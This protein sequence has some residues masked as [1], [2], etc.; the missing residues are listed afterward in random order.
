MTKSF[1]LVALCALGTACSPHES[2][3]LAPTDAGLAGLPGSAVGG[4]GGGGATDA[5]RDMGGAGA[6]GSGATGGGRD[7]RGAGAG[8]AGAGGRVTGGA[9]S[10]A[11]SATGTAMPLISRDVPAFAASGDPSAANDDAPATAWGSGALPS[12]IAYDLSATP[13]AERQQVLVAWY[14]IHAPCYIDE[15]ASGERPTAY[16]LETHSAPGGG[17]PP[18]SGWSTVLEIQDNRYCGRHH[19]LDLGGANWLRMNVTEGTDASV[20]F[21]LDVYSA[22]YG[23]SDSWL[24]MGDSITYMTM[25]HAFSDLS[26]LVAAARPDHFPAAIDAAL[27]GT[28]TSTA[29]E[30]IDDTM[31]DFP[32]RYVVLAYGTNDHESEF[33]MEELVQKVLAAGKTPVVPHMPWSEGSPEG[34]AINRLIDDLYAKY[35]ELVKGPDLWAVFENRTDLIPSGDVHPNDEGRE[36]LRKAW[37]AMMVETYE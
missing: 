35:P 4:A 33:Q 16:T 18:A 9:G 15:G 19:M 5:G 36:E 20:A 30:V 8:G 10:G 32:G 26:N 7:A 28:N 6:G 22:P 13:E 23:A 14:A 24:F 37:A 27:G 21:E 11:G 31:R 25:T 12:A 29:R 1:Y 3:S 34:A 2:D 17:G